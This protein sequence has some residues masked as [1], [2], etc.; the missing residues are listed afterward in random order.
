VAPPPSGP[1]LNVA[2]EVARFEQV[3]SEKAR[4]IS[5]QLE[6]EH[7]QSLGDLLVRLRAD[8]EEQT[9]ALSERLRSQAQ[10]SLEEMNSRRAELIELLQQET[11]KLARSTLA[12]WHATLRETLDSLS[13]VLRDKLGRNPP[14][15]SPGH[16]EPSE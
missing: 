12:H 16:Q 9:S 4:A 13:G 15:H 1:A 3:L 11:D 8:L 10:E 14:P 7:R 6:N 5:A 2:Q